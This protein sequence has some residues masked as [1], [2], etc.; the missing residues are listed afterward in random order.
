MFLIFSIDK[1]AQKS[2]VLV[3]NREPF[4]KMKRWRKR[5]RFMPKTMIF[6]QISF[7]AILPFRRRF[8]DGGG[9]DLSQR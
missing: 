8:Q 6:G 2:A 7:F 5:E 3:E 4:D 1:F 9:R